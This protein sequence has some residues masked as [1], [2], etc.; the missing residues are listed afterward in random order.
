M[1]II[2]KVLSQY[3]DILAEIELNIELRI[4][5]FNDRLI[6]IKEESKLIEV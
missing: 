3:P 4:K 6:R 5:E 1:E 2:D